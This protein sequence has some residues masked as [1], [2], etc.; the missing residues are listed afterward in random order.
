MHIDGVVCEREEVGAGAGQ[1]GCMQEVSFHQNLR[2]MREL[3][4]QMSRRRAFQ[5]EKQKMQRSGVPIVA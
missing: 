4:L 1:E 2:E 3:I 5:V